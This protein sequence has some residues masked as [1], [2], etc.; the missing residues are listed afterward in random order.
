MSRWSA[1]GADL[2]DFPD[3]CGEL[4]TGSTVLFEVEASCSRDKVLDVLAIVAAGAGLTLLAAS[5][6]DYVSVLHFLLRVIAS[7][8]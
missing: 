8:L 7:Q 3:P 2:S 1:L 6:I 5:L 4:A